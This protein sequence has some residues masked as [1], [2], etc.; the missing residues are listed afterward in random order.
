MHSFPNIINALDACFFTKHP[1]EMRVHVFALRSD[2][3]LIVAVLPS[4]VSGVVI[5]NGAVRVYTA[6]NYEMDGPGSESRQ[7]Y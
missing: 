4:V 1:R 2:W 7:G 5:S 6:T 3:E